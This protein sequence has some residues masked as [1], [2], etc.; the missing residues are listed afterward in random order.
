MIYLVY[1]RPK[2]G[3]TTFGASFDNVTLVDLERGGH[4]TDAKR[5]TPKD[6]TELAQVIG[7]HTSNPKGPLVVDSLTV[8]HKM[9]LDYVQGK[10]KPDLLSIKKPVSLPQYG[11]AN[12]L[13]SQLILTLRGL[14]TDTILICQERVTY[15]E[16]AEPE[17]D[18]V[19]SVRES[20]PDLPQG[21]RQT[22]L[23]YADVIG[24]SEAN[25]K[26]GKTTYRL[27]L[28]PTEGITAGCR[29]DITNRKPFL[30]NPTETRINTYLKG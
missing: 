10:T 22:A 11:Q 30:I 7:D 2:S 6:W 28:K 19:G 17:D 15:V 5:V 24:Y 23:M 25:T 27:W 16:Q 18:S 9:A 21:A 12:D 1:G 4:H 8:A 3:K 14:P 20:V 29:F 13:V 26:E